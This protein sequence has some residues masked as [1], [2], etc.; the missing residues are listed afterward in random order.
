MRIH[1]KFLV[2]ELTISL[3]VKKEGNGGRPDKVVSKK[4]PV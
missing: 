1:N 3:H 2:M 4:V